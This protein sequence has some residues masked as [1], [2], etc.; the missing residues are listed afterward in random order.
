MADTL[1]ETFYERADA[2]IRLANDQLH[3]PSVELSGG[4]VSASMMYGTA[5]FNAWVSASA[6]TSKE[7][8]ASVRDETIAYFVNGYRQMLEANIDQYIEN[9]DAYMKPKG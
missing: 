4:K 2:H 6:H 8:M 1:D 9:F 3:D 5:R 7:S